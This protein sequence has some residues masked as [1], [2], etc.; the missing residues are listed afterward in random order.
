[1][2]NEVISKL[3]GLRENDIKSNGKVIRK[4]MKDIEDY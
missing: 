4:K 2:K 3:F 1:M